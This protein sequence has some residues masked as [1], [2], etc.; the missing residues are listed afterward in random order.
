MRK[1]RF[2]KQS[3][4]TAIKE[5]LSTNDL[6]Y[7][8]IDGHLPHFLVAE[9]GARIVGAAGLEIHQNFALLRSLVV[10]SSE[11][12]KG[13]G[14]ILVQKILS[15]A[16]S[17]NIERVFLLTTTADQ[18]FKKIGFEQTDR[19]SVPIAIRNTKEFA[20]IC[21]STAVCMTRLMEQ[22]PDFNRNP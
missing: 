17:R 3:D 16:Q 18:F 14:S 15:Y 7:E 2:A 20:S 19:N 21:P 5:L 8:D 6:P 10:S 22:S 4:M 1:V 9:K 13:L 11:A 12:G